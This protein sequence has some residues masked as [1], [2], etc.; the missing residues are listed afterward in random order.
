MRTYWNA[1]KLEGNKLKCYNDRSRIFCMDLFFSWASRQ[2]Q[3]GRYIL[4]K[5]KSQLRLVLLLSYSFLFFAGAGAYTRCDFSWH[6]P[7]SHPF[8]FFFGLGSFCWYFNMKKRNIWFGVLIFVACIFLE[9][10]LP[11]H[12]PHSPL[13]SSPPLSWK[14]LAPS[15]SPVSSCAGEVFGKL[16]TRKLV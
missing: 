12:I 3:T 7:V 16:V 6:G 15:A 2:P 8:F 4:L 9:S 13:L 10:P 1:G 11:S 5:W 14:T